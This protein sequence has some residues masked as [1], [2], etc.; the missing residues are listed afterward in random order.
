MNGFGFKETIKWYD[1]NA[2]KYAD[3]TREGVS[4]DELTDFVTLIPNG[5]RILDV[6]CGSGR[7]T[8]LFTQG[9]FDVIG[10]DVSSGLIEE[11]K[12]RFP[13]SLFLEGNFLNL[14]FPND[15]IGGI[16]AHASLV[17]LE[18]IFEVQHVLSEF[19]RVLRSN[20]ILHVLVKAQVG[21]DKVAVVSDKLSDHDRFFRYFT[22]EEVRQYLE[23]AGFE[24]I[25]LDQYRETDKT[26][27]GR[28]EVEWILALS[29]KR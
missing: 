2:G 27:S 15:E 12:K 13:I 10:L 5:S 9:G 26:P 14:P 25:Q 8:H 1:Q 22:M 4:L 3:A 6:G 19:Y 28:P 24:V 17:H 29:R 21:E 11:A 16:W 23:Q 18:T 7:D 20:G